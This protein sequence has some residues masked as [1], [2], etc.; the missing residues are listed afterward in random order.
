MAKSSATKSKDI[1]SFKDATGELSYNLMNDYLFR[2][3]MQKNPEALKQIISAILKIPI[4][5]ITDLEITN[6]IKPG[7][8]IKFKEYRMDI[9]VRFR[10][11]TSIDIELQV[12]NEYNW[13][14]RGLVYLCREYDNLIERGKDYDNS[15]AAYQIGFLD[16]TLFKENEKFF[17]RYEMLDT[18]THYKYN[19]NYA[20]FVVDLSKINLATEEDKQ[21]GLDKW[22]KLFKATTWEEIKALVKEDIVMEA[23]ANDVYTSESDDVIRKRC[24]EREDYLRHERYVKERMAELTSELETVTSENET[25]TLELERLRAILKEHNISDES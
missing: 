6:S 22:C 17:S 3:V 20:L 10:N 24:R 25:L 14:T 18:D 12:N 8:A 16:F 21:V 19:S 7:D 9:T 1:P 11:T 23:V 2:I 4:E 5:T 13:R 15:L